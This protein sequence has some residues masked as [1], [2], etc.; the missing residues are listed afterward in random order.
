M[1]N[2]TIGEGDK[3]VGNIQATRDELSGI[4]SFYKRNKGSFAKEP[5]QCSG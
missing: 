1:R 5:I 2:V 4:G 3:C